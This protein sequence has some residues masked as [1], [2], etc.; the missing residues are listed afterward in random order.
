MDRAGILRTHV[1][2]RTQAGMEA[3][4]DLQRLAWEPSAQS[5]AGASATTGQVKAS[6]AST[7]A[8]TA[9]AEVESPVLR[10]MRERREREAAVSQSRVGVLG[11]IGN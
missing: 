9:A 6:A 3:W 4:E 5:K 8:T 7:A 10:R 11:G 2:T 1:Q